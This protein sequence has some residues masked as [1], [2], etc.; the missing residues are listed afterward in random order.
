MSRPKPIQERWYSAQGQKRL[1]TSALEQTSG[2]RRLASLVILL[3]MVLILIQQTSDV[4]KVNSVATAIGL[5]PNA[6]KLSTS[7]TDDVLVGDPAFQGEND[8]TRGMDVSLLEQVAMQA[9]TP[10]VFSYQQVWKALLKKASP[11]VVH[12]L[13]HLLYRK[14]A[15]EPVENSSTIQW[16]PIQEWYADS[17]L[18]LEKWTEI[19]T[20]EAIS[21]APSPA[22]E[23]PIPIFIDWFENQR[24]WFLESSM[25]AERLPQDDFSRGLSLAL[26][27]KILDQVADNSPWLST[28]RLPFVRSWQ[29]IAILRELLATKVAFPAHFQK[30]EVMQLLS[31]GQTHRGK[32]I[33]FDGTVYR[34]NRSAS[35]SE[36]G[37]DKT[38]YQ[39]IWLKPDETSNQPVCVYVPNENV[40]EGVKLEKD[41]HVTMTGIFFKRIA[42]ASQR[43]ADIAPLLLAAYVT[44]F[45]ATT[46]S[47][48]ADPFRILKPTRFEAKLWQPP[49]DTKSPLAILKDRMMLALESMDDANIE[50][51]F[52]GRVVSETMKPILEL[53]RLVPELDLLLQRKLEWP[54][55]EFATLARMAGTV[56]KIER[57]TI[58]PQYSAL[59]DRSHIYRCQFQHA[60]SVIPLLCASVPS[61][62][63]QADG[64]AFDAICQPCF[65]D[66]LSIARGDG[67]KLAW[68]LRP[69]WKLAEGPS[70]FDTSSI[71]PK[72]SE[73][74]QFLLVNGWDLAWMDRI[75]ELQIDPIKPLSPREMEPLFSLMRLAKQTP[76]AGSGTPTS[77]KSSDQS[78]VKLLD[79]LTRSNT[80]AKHV[81]E[82]VSMKVR[83]VRVSCVPIEDPT[84]AAILGIDL[85]YQLDGMADIGNRTYEKKE[86]NDPI[87]YH[88]EYPV[89]C[90]SIDIP[91][92]LMSDQQSDSTSNI[93][94]V[95]YP[96]TKATAAGW[97]YRF[98]NYKTQET[99]QS[100]HTN[101]QQ[102]GPL[103]VL[104]ELELGFASTDEN[105]SPNIASR[106][107]NA[108]TVI[109]G[110]LGTI[111][112]WWFV[113]RSPSCLPGRK[114]RLSHSSH[115][116]LN[117]DHKPQKFQ[118]KN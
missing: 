58:D 117:R 15:K 114:P 92:W 108:I 112:I 13:S 32:P 16:T 28:D 7:Q 4:R 23:T 53:E 115:S 116:K 44:P 18:Q 76:F 55:S 84:Q 81:M 17:K 88:K 60:G 62:W 104:D 21:K 37:F 25:V 73:G 11:P 93:Q 87:I 1:H 111:G 56:T 96:R 51:G 5:L 20:Q 68:T 82:R 46:T 91:A 94:Q 110:V 24:S 77:S 54:I 19:E 10:I 66:G 45:E 2:P 50:S 100:L 78:I 59:L 102:I 35:I 95:W 39:V 72:I 89:T 83:I 98:W 109:I 9:A 103:I 22:S 113:R 12:A 41:S 27:E 69:N 43:G 36:A 6:N 47:A 74:M 86:G 52:H 99:T 67:T 26:D 107:S 71:T 30:V 48:S 40:D 49:V 8:D 97:F 34:I 79:T 3:V 70:T 118:H 57:M 90:V 29:R 61:D 38:E 75:R 63:L 80:K 31:N 65:V 85:Y 33:R 105:A 101:Q 14:Q 64:N 106:M 42:Y